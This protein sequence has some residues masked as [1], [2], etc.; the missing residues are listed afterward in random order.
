MIPEFQPFDFQGNFQSTHRNLPHWQQ[1]GATYFV[2]FRLADSLP[3]AE[4]ERWEEMRQLNPS[5]NFD[6]VE[7]YLD[8]G[9]GNCILILIR[10][11][12][13]IVE[14]ALRHFDGERLVLGAYAIMPNHVHVLTQPRGTTTLSSMLQSWK[15]FTA[16]K[17]NQTLGWS[18]RIWQAESFD[19]IV[20]DENELRKCHSYIL[21]NPAAACLRP[22]TFKV[23]C[24]SARWLEIPT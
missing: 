4:L 6:W 20:R 2:T 24:G 12:A 13:Q 15:S 16:H 14:D 19:R 10:K 23:G 21:E 7:R 22:G 3:A 5:E 1:E 17:I 11:C 8:A 18:G 9:S